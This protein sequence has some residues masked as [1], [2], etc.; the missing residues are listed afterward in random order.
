MVVT[1]ASGM[2]GSAIY[3][4][5][6]GD[7]KVDV[8]GWSH[9]TSDGKLEAF[10]LPDFRRALHGEEIDL[11]IHCA[12]LTDADHCEK[13]SGEA[14]VINALIPGQL[15]GYARGV[16]ARFVYVSTDAVY[17][18]SQPGRR[19]ETDQPN[20]QS[21]YAKTK[22]EGEGRV[23]AAYPEALVVRTT[24]FG[25]TLP[26]APRPKFAEQ[27]LAA[28][29]A[30]QP[31]KLFRDAYFSPLHVDL[32]GEC[33]LELAE[34]DASGVLNVGAAN[35]VSKAAFGHFLAEVFGLDPS[36]I[37]E[38]SVDDVPLAAKR[39]KNVSLDVSECAK[40]LGPLPTVSQGVHQ[41]YEEAF[42]GT[43]ARIRGRATYP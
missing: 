13:N 32:L 43:A 5:L 40:L 14:S 4:E 26:T 27:I 6:R 39:T 36:P 1:G 34:A 2:L 19:K 7:R 21:V 30:R 35:P 22:L 3:R 18:D 29:T 16:G 11:I 42:N 41:L 17:D 37:E 15:A 24:M 25:W 10:D 9:T 23:L 12:A 20:P 33:L 8:R 28:L 31:I 38:V